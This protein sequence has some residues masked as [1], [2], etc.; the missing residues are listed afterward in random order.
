[1]A[2]RRPNIVDFLIILT[3]VAVV[4]LAILK[5]GVV[6]RVESSGTDEAAIRTTYTAFVDKVRMPTVN[7]LHE[8]D[9]IFDE[10]TGICIGEIKGVEYEPLFYNLP[11]GTGGMVRAQYPDYYRVT[12]TI[13]GSL[14]D[15]EDGYF[16][17]GVVELKVNSEM[18]VFT[19]YA[20]PTIKVSNIEM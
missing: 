10:K 9:L 14:V 7:A 5:L 2:K 6:N 12:M 17:D 1:M 11:D 20:K 15:K 19:K 3:L 8:G 16:V 18:N 13:E 4:V